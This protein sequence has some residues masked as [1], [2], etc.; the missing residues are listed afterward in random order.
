[1][2]APQGGWAGGEGT[3][4]PPSLYQVPGTLW[5][6]A[7]SGF[8]SMALPLDGRVRRVR[9]WGRRGTRV[10]GSPFREK[11]ELPWTAGSSSALCTEEEYSQTRDV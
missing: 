2:E 1:M 7:A 4:A 8:Q 9:G 3:G 5:V 6:V 10:R 11:E